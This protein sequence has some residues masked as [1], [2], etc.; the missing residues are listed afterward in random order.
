MLD[1]SLRLIPDG[2]EFRIGFEPSNQSACAA[3]AVATIRMCM[4]LGRSA[5]FGGQLDFLRQAFEAAKAKFVQRFEAGEPIVEN[6]SRF[7][8]WPPTE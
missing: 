5:R 2:T 4:F 1:W 7:N 6:L 8:P 3:L